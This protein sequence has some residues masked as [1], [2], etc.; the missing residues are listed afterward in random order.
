[1]LFKCLTEHATTCTARHLGKSDCKKNTYFIMTIVWLKC[2][3]DW[4]NYR[5]SCLRLNRN[6]IPVYITRRVKWID[7][8]TDLCLIYYFYR[9]KNEF[10]VFVFIYNLPNYF[11][12]YY[13]H[14][15]YCLLAIVHKHFF[16][17]VLSS[18][19][20]VTTLDVRMK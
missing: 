19:G 3:A 7:L 2:E 14:I 6:G 5:C 17:G 4:H 16:R 18:S 15:G 11:Y 20:L 1:M 10:I 9:I 13:N 8:I 12:E